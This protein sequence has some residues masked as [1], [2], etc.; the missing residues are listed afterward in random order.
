NL[1]LQDLVAGAVRDPELPLD[2]LE[3]GQQLGRG[4]RHDL[5]DRAHQVPIATQ[6]TFLP[7]VVAAAGV[8][9]VPVVFCQVLVTSDPA[10]G[11]P[12]WS[13]IW[14]LAMNGLSVGSDSSEATTATTVARPVT[15][16]SAAVTVV[17]CPRANFST[18]PFCAKA[19][20][21]SMSRTPP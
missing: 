17:S 10:A 15:T 19:P 6:L 5:D 2:A 9:S 21:G 7:K 16:V 3:R 14:A 8:G 12:T 20:P 1:V 11:A 4:R 18:W 13:P